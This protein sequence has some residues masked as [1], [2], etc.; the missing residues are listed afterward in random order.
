MTREAVVRRA[1]EDAA[2]VARFAGGIAVLA[3]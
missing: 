1:L 2:D 3:E